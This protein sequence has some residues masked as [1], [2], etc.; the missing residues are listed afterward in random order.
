MVEIIKFCT[1]EKKELS[2]V[3]GCIII[4]L[5][6]DLR[7]KNIGPFVY[8]LGRQVFI[9]ERGVRLPYGLQAF[10][11]IIWQIINLH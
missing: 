9:L 4:F 1:L 7:P 5:H 2:V 3:L 8:R 6:V 10:K 11:I